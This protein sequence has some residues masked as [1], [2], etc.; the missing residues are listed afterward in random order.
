MGAPFEAGDEIAFFSEDGTCVGTR[1]WTGANVALTLW[2]D[3]PV[4]PEKDGLYA[5]EKIEVRFWQQATDIEFG[6]SNGTIGLNYAENPPFIRGGT[7]QHDGLYNLSGTTV[8]ATSPTGR[9]KVATSRGKADASERGDNN[10]GAFRITR[11]GSLEKALTVFF[12][13]TGSAENGVDY[14]HIDSFATIEPGNTATF[15]VVEP[16]PDNGY[17]GVETVS[18]ELLPHEEYEVV[19]EDVSAMLTIQDGGPSTVGLDDPVAEANDHLRAFP[20]PFVDAVSVDYVAPENDFI[21]VALYDA[22]GRSVGAV[23]ERS[24]VAGEQYRF[25]LPAADLPVGVY[26]VRLSGKTGS[27]TSTVTRLR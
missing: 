27:I 9:N 10:T 23:R 2:G 3:N 16:V 11:E 6:G 8:E 12:A 14:A 19:Q 17:E 26:F 22:L 5:G 1:T 24:V 21:S 7:Y 20:N 4:T 25:E 15:V 13:V 18:L